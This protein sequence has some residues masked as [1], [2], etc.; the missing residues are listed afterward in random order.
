MKITGIYTITNLIDNKI[1][2]GYSIH[3]KKRLY[4][5]LYKLKLKLHVNSHLQRAFSKY[6]EENFQFEILEECDKSFLTSQE[7]YWC[8]ILNT[9]NRRFG[10]NI[11][12]TNPDYK[13]NK[14]SEETKNK[15]RLSQ[16][17]IK[18]YIKR[19]H[20]ALSCKK[21]PI[22]ITE[23]SFDGNI[24]K[25][26]NKISDASKFYNIDPAG[27]RNCCKRK[28]NN[29]KGKYWRY[30][31]ELFEGNSKITRRKKVI[32][33]EDNKI[34]N[35]ISDAAKDLKCSASMISRQLI[36]KYKHVKGFTFI[37]LIEGSK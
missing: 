3:I 18:D 19:A 24:I 35:S 2:V 13:L 17:N 4:S 5:H 11:L 12:P 1:Y 28:I 25:E 23:F 9:H 7:N 8:N 27:I 21:P 26:W 16:L 36:G 31:N 6:G 15:I 30:K 34:F 32:R 22:K 29:Y 37:F 20:Y 14:H 10:Y 33:N